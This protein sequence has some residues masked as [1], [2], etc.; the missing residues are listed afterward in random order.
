MTEHPHGGGRQV[1]LRVGGRPGGVP[2]VQAAGHADVAHRLLQARAARP[3]E[4]GGHVMEPI[5]QVG[6]VG[7]GVGGRAPELRER[8]RG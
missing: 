5:A 2:L 4:A 3:G 7:A 1:L 8:Q 6:R